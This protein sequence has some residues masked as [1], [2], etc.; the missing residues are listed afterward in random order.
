MIFLNEYIKQH[1]SEY[2]KYPGKTI[3]LYVQKGR[4][5]KK[6]CKNEKEV[7]ETIS[8]NGLL[9]KLTEPIILT[10][11]KISLKPKPRRKIR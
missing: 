8:K 9:D 4:L 3:L 10:M 11:P 6:I 7:S 2:K 1:Y 5:F